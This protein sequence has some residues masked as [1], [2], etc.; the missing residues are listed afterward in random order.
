MARDK[1]TQSLE[2]VAW[3]KAKGE[4]CEHLQEIARQQIQRFLQDL[5][6]QEAME[7]L[8]RQKYQRKGNPLEEKGYRNRHG[9]VRRFTLSLGTVE[10]KRPRVRNLEERDASRFL[11][12]D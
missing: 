6:E 8:G 4:F 7:L 3:A 9:K 5:L 11:D 2:T 1:A 10:V 12:S